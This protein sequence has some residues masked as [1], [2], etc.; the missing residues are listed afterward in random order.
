MLL[1]TNECFSLG[2]RKQ[3][4]CEVKTQRKSLAGKTNILHGDIINMKTTPHTLIQIDDWMKE[5]TCAI[6]CTLRHASL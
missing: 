1:V 3:R 2:E 5:R 4:T 6:E